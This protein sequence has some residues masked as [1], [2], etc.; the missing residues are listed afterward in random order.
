[1]VLQSLINAQRADITEY[2]N[3]M[4][5]RVFAQAKKQVAVATDDYM[6]LELDT[7]LFK[8]ELTKLVSDIDADAQGLIATI[9]TASVRDKIDASKMLNDYNKMCNYLNSRP[10]R[11]L[12]TREQNEILESINPLSDPINT[13]ILMAYDNADRI[14][15]ERGARAGITV[16]EYFPLI[17]EVKMMYENLT[18]QRYDIIRSSQ[19]AKDI[20]IAIKEARPAVL[21]AS[22]QIETRVPTVL[23]A[24][25]VP[26]P[27]PPGTPAQRQPGGQPGAFIGMPQVGDVAP[28][29]YTFTQADITRLGQIDTEQQ[30]VQT[31]KRRLEGELPRLQTALTRSESKL[32]AADTKIQTGGMSAAKLAR[33]RQNKTEAEAD[34]AQLQ[35]QIG[36]T[37]TDIQNVD[38][39]LAR[40]SAE[41]QGILSGGVAALP[42]QQQAGAT[43]Q[44]LIAQLDAVMQQLGANIPSTTN[45]GYEYVGNGEE[46]DLMGGTAA[47]SDAQ[48]AEYLQ[49]GQD[50]L[51]Q[52]AQQQGGQPQPQPGPAPA[53]QGYVTRPAAVLTQPYLDAI[54]AYETQAG[55][56]ASQDPAAAFAALPQNLQQEQIA[57]HGDEAG[58]IRDGFEPMLD[59][60]NMQRAAYA[61]ANQVGM[62]SLIG[63]A[64]PK[65]M[66]PIS[67]AV[68]AMAEH[69]K[70]IAKDMFMARRRI[71]MGGSIIPKTILNEGLYDHY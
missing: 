36:Q 26:G 23:P 6:P 49:V 67:R 70:Q 39:D 41:K 16:R 19:L 69:A 56:P 71:L 58:A 45:I 52:Q 40:L 7:K 10:Y 15:R 43:R 5:S 29:G 48:L 31:E 55:I 44:G 32:A 62:D 37:Q 68:K 11:A 17:N 9:S 34:I 33:A 24:A 42:Q 61:R 13:I 54:L 30:R 2:D 64:K 12:S 25:L 21:A 14:S 51:A 8:F 27:K 20:N 35:P 46:N 65:S 60:V 50:T 22:E 38:Q 59:Q 66:K 63:Q 1:M 3:R 4:Q 53:Q 18:V 28:N 47:A 57:A